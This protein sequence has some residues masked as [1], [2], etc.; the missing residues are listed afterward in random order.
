MLSKI[1]R[2]WLRRLATSRG[3][4]VTFAQEVM[5]LTMD[6][7]ANVENILSA[8]YT[9]VAKREI[10][11]HILGEALDR[12]RVCYPNAM[13]PSV[14]IGNWQAWIWQYWEKDE[15]MVV[16]AVAYMILAYHDGT[17]GRKS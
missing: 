16:S 4:S 9:G 12:A 14:C 17:V 5:A 8:F 15:E 11:E 3:N 1:E 2:D 6:R 13:I 10:C 7:D